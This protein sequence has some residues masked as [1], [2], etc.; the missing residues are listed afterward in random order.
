M[1]RLMCGVDEITG[2]RRELLM[3]IDESRFDYKTYR[4]QK[5]VGCIVQ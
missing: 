3:V 5:F 2:A 1:F 4:F